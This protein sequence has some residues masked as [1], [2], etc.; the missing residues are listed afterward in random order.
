MRVNVYKSEASFLKP[1]RGSFD[2]LL[3][4]HLSHKGPTYL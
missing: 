2:E 3:M 4:G 1:S